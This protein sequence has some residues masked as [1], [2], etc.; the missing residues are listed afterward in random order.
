MQE[1]TFLPNQKKK[2][3]WTLVRL[4]VL[5]LNAWL[6]ARKSRI[7]NTHNGF[8]DNTSAILNL[9]PLQADMRIWQGSPLRKIYIWHL[10]TFSR[11]GLYALYV[12][13]LLTWTSN[14]FALLDTGYSEAKCSCASSVSCKFC[15][16][17]ILC[18]TIWVSFSSNISVLANTR[19]DF[20]RNRHFGWGWSVRTHVFKCPKRGRKCF[21]WRVCLQHTWPIRNLSTLR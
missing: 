13:L 10:W 9:V 17:L 3:T 2:K 15:G 21:C 8:E 7:N 6:K 11:R 14:S 5:V 1:R 19:A 4:S 18:D 16:R 12:C 20:L